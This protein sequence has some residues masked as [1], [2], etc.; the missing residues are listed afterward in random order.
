MNERLLPTKPINVESNPAYASSSVEGPVTDEIYSYISDGRD[1]LTSS[2][3]IPMGSNEAYSSVTRGEIK[4][5]SN[6]NVGEKREEIEHD[7]VVD[8]LVYDTEMLKTNKSCVNRDYDVNQLATDV[9]RDCSEPDTD[10]TELTI[11]EAYVVAN[12]AT[13]TSLISGV[14]TPG[15]LNDVVTVYE[16]ATDLQ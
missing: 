11:N 1:L 3:P 4:S 2:V 6:T 12:R 10:I 5:P 8:S 13:S 9:K 14:N 16:S 7:Y 15:R